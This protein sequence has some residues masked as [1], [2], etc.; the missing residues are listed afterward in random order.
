MTVRPGTASLGNARN[1]RRGNNG[2]IKALGRITAQWTS[3]SCYS[4]VKASGRAGDNVDV[5]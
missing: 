2:T 4:Q 5:R 1:G 3:S